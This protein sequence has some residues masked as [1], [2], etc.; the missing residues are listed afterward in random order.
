MTDSFTNCLKN[1][2]ELLDRYKT[3][4]YQ[5][6]IKCFSYDYTKEITL[7]REETMKHLIQSCSFIDVEWHYSVAYLEKLKCDILAIKKFM[8]LVRNNKLDDFYQTFLLDIH[9]IKRAILLE[10]K[11]IR[12]FI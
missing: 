9:D 4:S 10:I 8:K 6:K 2:S 3:T 11:D 5:I 7:N 1:I 12:R